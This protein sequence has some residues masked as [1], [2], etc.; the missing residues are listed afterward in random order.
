MPGFFIHNGKF[1]QENDPVISPDNRSFRYGDGV[2]ETLRF[3]LN[4]IPLWEFHQ[5]RLFSALEKLKFELPKLFTPTYLH[6]QVNSLISK[7]KLS[8]ARVRIT[9]YR[10]DGGLTDRTPLHP[11]FVIQTWP[12]ADDALAFNTNGLHIGI[13]EEGRKAIDSFANIKSNNFLVYVQAAIYAREQKW[14]DALVLNTHDRIADS[15]IANIFWVK[16]HRIFTPPLS[17]APVQ[18]VMRRQL[19]ENIPIHELSLTPETLLVA[20]EVFLTN[21]V[22]GIQWVA[23][24]NDKPY[25]ANTVAATLYDQFVKPL[26]H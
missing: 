8:R 18:G 6:S 15:T 2:F 3:H 19:L 9:V 20:D 22:R 23:S 1:H 4:D 24:V 26:F 11:G 5:Q 7:N 12:I 25:G 14:N 10:G 17:E 13:F 16:D 21:A